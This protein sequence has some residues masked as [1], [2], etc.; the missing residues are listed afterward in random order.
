MSDTTQ[1]EAA[2]GIPDAAAVE[3]TLESLFGGQQETPERK[4]QEAAPESS[5]EV[6]SE[7]DALAQDL[8]QIEGEAE[9]D[10][11]APADDAFEIV[12]NGQTVKLSRAEILEKAQKGFDYDRKVQAATESYKALQGGLQR[13]QELEQAQPYLIQEM[14]QV[15]AVH[16]QLQ[17]PRYSDAELLKLAQSGDLIEYQTRAAER[18]MLRN[19]LQQGL[20]QFQQKQQAVAQ[21]REQL[22]R[23]QLEQENARLP[24]VIPAWRDNAK[25][26]ADKADMAKYLQSLGA[27]MSQVGRYLDNALAMKITRDAMNYQRLSRMRADKSKQ[28]RDAPP[29]VRPGRVAPSDGKTAE[30]NVSVAVRKASRSGDTHTAEKLVTSL[31]GRAFPK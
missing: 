9:P 2:V 12:H 26:E 29:V 14:G 10:K 5:D 3:S 20:A 8:A 4:A 19:G 27:D 13:L 15:A 17:S 18:D 16:S 28:L 30:R 7:S 6:Q 23:A 25:M 31:L 11:T 21:Y 24:E 22:T 1:P